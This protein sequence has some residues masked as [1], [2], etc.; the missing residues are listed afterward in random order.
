MTAFSSYP[1]ENHLNIDKRIVIVI[2]RDVLIVPAEHAIRAGAAV[3]EILAGFPAQNVLAF[4]T[5]KVIVPRAAEQLILA[6][7]A[8]DDIAQ[9]AAVN[10][11]GAVAAADQV[12]FVGAGVADGVDAIVA[13][14]TDDRAASGRQG[15]GGLHP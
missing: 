2:D 10:R 14:S 7:L 6:V 3:Q 5:E 8:E 11:V 4:A 1:L 15:V 12:A 13:V 9:E